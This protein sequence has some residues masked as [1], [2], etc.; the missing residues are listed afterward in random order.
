MMDEPDGRAGFALQEPEVTEQGGDFAGRILVDGVQ[1]DQRIQDQ[2]S[3]PVKDE[4]GFKPLLIGGSIQAQGR[5]DDDAEIDVRQAKPAL[6]NE[7]F[8]SAA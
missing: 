4:C 7:R 8:Q 3:G 1:A 6:M 5:I 2:Q